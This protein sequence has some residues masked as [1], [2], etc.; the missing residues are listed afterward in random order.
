[1]AASIV[2]YRFS[3]TICCKKHLFTKFSVRSASKYS[4][5]IDKVEEPYEDIR[6]VSRLPERLK[7]KLK[8]NTVNAMPTP[9]YVPNYLTNNSRGIKR[10]KRKTFAK[11]GQKYDINPATLWP[12]EEELE[13]EKLRNVYF[14]PPLEESMEKLRLSK[15]EEENNIRKRSVLCQYATMH[16]MI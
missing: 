5:T 1:M 2:R 8:K 14:D 15:E 3:K 6:D 7:V 10:F 11:Y 9:D 13:K 12:T 4:K 16:M